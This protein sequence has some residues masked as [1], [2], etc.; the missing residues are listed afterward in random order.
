[1]KSQRTLVMGAG[2]VGLTTAIGLAAAGHGVELVEIRPDRLDALRAGRLPIYEPGLSDAFADAATRSRITISQRPGTTPIDVVL[3]CVGTPLDDQG[4]SDLSQ[5][6]SA[7]DA[8]NGHLASGAVLVIRSTLPVGSSERVLAWSKATSSRTFTNPEFLR[9]GSALQDFLHPTRLVIGRFPDADPAA[10]QQVLALLQADESA[11][12]R[13][14]GV[15]EADLIKNG[16]NA[17]LA[18]KL[19]F[20]NELATLC[21]EMS[22]DIDVVLEAIGLDPRIGGSYLKPSFGFGGSCL[23]KELGTLANAG[24]GRGLPMH[25]TSAASEANAS[26]QRRFAQR[27]IAD[28]G[29][30]TNKRIALL[31]LAFKAGTDDIRSSPAMH[32]AQALIEAGADVIAHDPMAAENALRALPELRIADT[33]EE[34]LRGAE[35][36]IIATEWPEYAGLD[37]RSIRESMV[38]PVIFDGRRLLRSANLPGLGF[39]YEAVGSPATAEAHVTKTVA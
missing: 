18:L 35:V 8:A 34:A 11:P 32:V 21:E 1:M 37:W 31:G 14:V 2:Y 12:V 19:S 38:S 9:Q 20:A 23:P 33:A 24:L 5:V 17:F 39:R 16:A 27:V 28:L 29:D 13:V 36:A 6:E 3:L 10:L 7:L 25:V 22:A 26:H 30:P 15:E 4:R